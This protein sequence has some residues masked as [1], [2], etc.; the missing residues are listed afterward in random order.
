VV[1]TLE[2][3]VKIDQIVIEEQLHEEGSGAS[4]DDELGTELG[5]DNEFLGEV[6]DRS[7]LSSPY[8]EAPILEIHSDA[9]A[10]EV[11]FLFC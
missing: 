9:W 11:S 6:L 7:P 1:Q 10:F 8:E 2:E 5:E 4:N 3:L